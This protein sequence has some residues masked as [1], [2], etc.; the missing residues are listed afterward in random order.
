MDGDE[1]DIDVEA[2]DGDD[3]HAGDG[4]D[5]TKEDEY[6]PRNRVSQY[7]YFDESYRLMKSIIDQERRF[8]RAKLNGTN[9]CPSAPRQ[10]KCT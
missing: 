10:A 7:Y 5:A 2:L 8:R 4:E 1:G 9:D 3:S 6:V